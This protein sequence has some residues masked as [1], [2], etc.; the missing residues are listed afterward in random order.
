MS[1]LRSACFRIDAALRQALR[2]RG[3]HVVGR[4]HLQHR[5]PRVA[6]Q[7]GGDRVAEHERRHDRARRDWPPVLE[8]AHEA[9][10]RQPAE[11]DREQQDQHDAEPEVR[12][13]QAP[14]RDDVRARSPTRCCACTAETMPAGMPIASAMRI[15]K[16]A[17]SSV[18][19]SFS[20]MSSST[21]FCMR[22][23]SPRSP[24]STP[25]DPVQVAHRQ[26][27]VEVQLLAQVRDDGRVAVLAGQH[28]RGIARQQL[29]QA[30]DQH[31]DEDERRDDRRDAADEVA[32]ISISARRRDTLAPRGVL[33]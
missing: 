3:A 29:L 19:G 16:H 30:E 20:R 31:R 23:D 2:A 17:S 24:C 9:R 33:S 6:H 21:G 7:H 18:T 13:R 14:Q 26:R 32:N 10:R 28:D 4:Q 22:S 25:V 5:A 12:R 11:R 27:L 15:A 1:A 8:R